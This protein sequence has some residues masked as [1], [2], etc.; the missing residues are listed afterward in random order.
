MRRARW[1]GLISWHP[2]QKKS[3]KNIKDDAPK[4]VYLSPE[5]ECE[6]GEKPEWKTTNERINGCRTRRQQRSSAAQRRW[7]E[8]A[9]RVGLTGAT[10]LASSA[11]APGP[12]RKKGA[13]PNSAVV[14]AQCTPSTKPGTWP[15][16]TSILW[17]RP[18]TLFP[19]L[20]ILAAWHPP[21]LHA[22]QCATLGE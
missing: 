7:R 10:P 16:C 11:L 4:S 14:S 2:E 20:T 6:K 19:F 13:N 1:K 8:G 5:R 18:P 15:D 22:L 17:H 12:R 21:S 3:W 9:A